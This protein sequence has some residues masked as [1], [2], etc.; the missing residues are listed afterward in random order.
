MRIFETRTL[1]E[2][3]I[4]KNEPRPSPVNEYPEQRKVDEKVPNDQPTPAISI[5][6]QPPE[7]IPTPAPKTPVIASFV[8]TVPGIRS[9]GSNA[10]RLMRIPPAN[11]TVQITL[12]FPD[13][14]ADRYSRYR[15]AIQ[16]STGR[17]IWSRSDIKG[18]R[19]RSGSSLL[20]KAPAKQLQTGPHSLMLSGY[21]NRGEWVDIREFYIRVER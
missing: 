9:L 4:V 20:L 8:W 2:Q 15:A 1:N 11:E 18:S 3:E 19:V 17:E 5:I 14:P 6:E 16:N 7:V 21:N 13:L 12:N 10:P